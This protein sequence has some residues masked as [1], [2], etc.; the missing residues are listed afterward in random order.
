MRIGEALLERDHLSSR[1]DALEARLLEDVGHGRP[2]A[3]LLREIEQTSSRILALQNAIDWTYQHLLV[4]ESALGAHINK[5]EHFQRV[6]D[7]LENIDSPDLRERAD[8]LHE[9]RKST[10]VLI[11]TINWAYDLQL[12]ES[13][14]PEEPEEED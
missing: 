11:Q 1:L 8:E 6:A 9:A 4:G 13:K 7:L 2:L 3:H 12:P 10:E 14:V 5:S